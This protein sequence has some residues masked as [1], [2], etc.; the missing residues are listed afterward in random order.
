MYYKEVEAA[1]HGQIK[2]VDKKPQDINTD[3]TEVE[4]DFHDQ[5]MK[6]ERIIWE[7]EQK[8]REAQR[9]LHVHMLH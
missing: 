9:A 7:T 4:S 1:L 8:A 3:K 2:E 6:L 5:M